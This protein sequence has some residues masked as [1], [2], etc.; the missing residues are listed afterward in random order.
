MDGYGCGI[1]DCLTCRLL[2]PDWRAEVARQMPERIGYGDERTWTWLTNDWQRPKQIAG[3]TGR[4]LASTAIA[5]RRLRL[6]CP[7]AIDYQRGLG[8][9]RRRV[10]A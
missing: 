3:R 1:D 7:E 5:L 4:T 6:R 9:R 8:Y 2:G 10:A